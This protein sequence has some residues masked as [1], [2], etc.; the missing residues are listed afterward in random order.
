MEYSAYYVYNLCE[1]PVAKVQQNLEITLAKLV[2]IPSIT[3][4]LDACHEAIDFVKSEIKDLGLF[5]HHEKTGGGAPWMVAT[6]KDTKTPDILLM[7]HLDVVPAPG[8]MF[9]LEERGDKLYGRGVYDM[10]LAAACY[11]ELLKAHKGELSHLNIG[12]LFTTD[13]ESHSKSMHDVLAWGLRPKVVLL[14]DGGDD[15]SIEKRAKGLYGVEIVAHGRTSHGSRPWEGENAL[16]VILDIIQ[17]L[18]LKYPSNQP[19][20]ATLSV[21]KI[22]AGEAINQVPHHASVMLDFRSFDKQELDEY[23]ALVTKLTAADNITLIPMNSGDPLL[24][25]AESPY[26]QSF[27]KALQKQ[28]GSK[29]VHFCESYGASDARFFTHYNIPCIIIEP[30]GGGRHSND[31]WLEMADLEKFYQLIERWV[32]SE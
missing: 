14:P 27:V 28:T 26:V 29:D 8:E 23:R 3:E 21:N 18:R 31:E 25:D 22:R 5:I 19:S 1:G 15:W 16:H 13:E 11:I 9:A 7:A 32:F 6:T 2:F 4:D 12:L 24:F 20:E 10:K 30:H 17:K